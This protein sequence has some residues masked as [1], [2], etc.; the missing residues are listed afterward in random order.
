[1]EEEN[2]WDPLVS[3][4]LLKLQKDNAPSSTLRN[5]KSDLIQFF[6]TR[7]PL[8]SSARGGLE[9]NYLTDFSNHLQN[10]LHLSSSTIKRKSSAVRSFLKWARKKGY[11]PAPPVIPSPAKRDEGSHPTTKFRW[12]F[13]S[14]NWRIGMTWRKFPISR[15]FTWALV[16]ILA[17]AFGIG[18]YEQFFSKTKKPQAFPLE[19]TKAVRTV[20]FQGRL[21]DSSNN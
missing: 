15:Y 11:F 18:L 2:F 14:A 1:M 20:N 10:N 8:A 21:T 5:Y 3:K 16:T 6:S 7:P 17:V 13:L 9:K 12:G 19:P 4:F